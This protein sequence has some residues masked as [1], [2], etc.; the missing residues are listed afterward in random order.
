MR[1]ANRYL[2]RVSRQSRLKAKGKGIMRWYWELCTNLLAFTLQLRKA[3]EK[4]SQ[5]TVYDGCATSHR[6]K[7]GLLPPNAVGR[8]AQNVRKGE[9]RK[10]RKGRIRQ[11]SVIT[12][13]ERKEGKEGVKQNYNTNVQVSDHLYLLLHSYTTNLSFKCFNIIFL[14][15]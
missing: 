15:Y 14:V 1:I 2:S 5:E 4:G 9:G 11:N 7:W 13:F 12:L 8:I 6:L 3:P 10:E